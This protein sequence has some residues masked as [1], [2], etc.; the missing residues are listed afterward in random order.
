MPMQMSGVVPVTVEDPGVLV[1]SEEKR[2]HLLVPAEEEEALS[3]AEDMEHSDYDVFA[4]PA[5]SWASTPGVS[6]LSCSS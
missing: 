1:A 6:A 2:A 5:P 4:R 3:V